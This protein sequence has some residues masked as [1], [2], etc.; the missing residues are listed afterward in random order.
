MGVSVRRMVRRKG[1]FGYCVEGLKVL[2]V[3]SLAKGKGGSSEGSARGRRL[4]CKC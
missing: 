4:E 3:R 2:G 1:C